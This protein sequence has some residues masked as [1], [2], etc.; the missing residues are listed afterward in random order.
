MFYPSFEEVLRLKDTYSF[1]PISR[2]VW[3]DNLTPIRLFQQV[4][5]AYSFLLESVEGGEQWGRY[6]FI[7]NRPFVVF[8]VR[9]G[10]GYIEPLRSDGPAKDSLF[11][12]ELFASRVSNQPLELLKKLLRTY[13]VPQELDLPPFSGG[14]IG[15]VGYDAI[16]LVEDIPKHR[17]DI[18]EQDQ[19]RLMF[20]DEMIAFDHLQQEI[21]FISHLRVD[22]AQTEEELKLSYEETC[23]R[24]SRRIDRV[25]KR[26]KQ[27][28]F[29]LFHLPSERPQV[30][31][32]QVSSN[33][34]RQSFLE[35][36]Q[37]IKKYIRAGDVFQ[38]VLSQRFTLDIETDPFNIYRV[39]RMVN[40]SPYLYYLDLGDGIN[41]IGSSPE[42][43]VKLVGNKAETNPIAGT[44]P[45]GKTKEE[46]EALARELLADEKERAEHHMLLDLGRNDIGRV[47]QFGT[48]QVTKH[49]QIE[50]FSHVMHICSTV[51]GQMKDGH[52]AVDA[53]FA[54]FPAGTVTG[55]PK[56]RAMEIVAE[57]ENDARHAYSG[58]VG[59]FSFSGNHDSCIA[60]RTIFVHDGKAH[61]Q[62]GAGIV[63][64]S[65]PEKEWQETRNKARAM[66]VAVQ[67]AEKIFERTNQGDGVHV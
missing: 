26:L 67:L 37:K 57:L 42:R 54:C 36:V 11:S 49:M 18:F 8:S 66:L 13:R 33:F 17:Q 59:Y 19:I 14:A 15:Y 55:A 41:I 16:T 65:V 60:I 62:A 46:D 1:I 51:E 27:D 38:T 31:W 10:K 56:I 45:R 43:L 2:K 9:D 34:D 4:K 47:A 6:S 32:S 40:P 50:K 29:E 63:A 21:T 48:V 7:G 20:C 44:R 25:F 61:I 53:L 23:A 28:E 52:D 35:S 22:R 64:D 12:D 5:E 58:A 30:D 24:I 3:S 39:L